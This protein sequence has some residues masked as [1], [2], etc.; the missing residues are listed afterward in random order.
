MMMDTV[1]VTFENG[2]KREYVKGI[3]FRDIIEDIDEQ[4]NFDV[5]AGMYNNQMISYDDA[6][7]KS[8]NLVLYDINTKQGNKIYE[9][10]LLFL[11]KVCVNE[12]L[13]SKVYVKVKYSIDHGIFC[14]ISKNINQEEVDKIKILMKEKVKKV[15]PFDRVETSRVE[16]INYFKKIKREDKV[17]TLFYNTSNFVTLYRFDGIYDYV[18]GDLPNDSSVFKYFD[19]T[20]IEGKGIVLR[21]PSIYDN[22]K[23]VKY[24]HHE[25]YFNSLEEYNEWGDLLNISNL[26][27]LNEAIINNNAGEIVQLS[28]IIQNYKLLS[29]A[30]SIAL[31]K[32]KI[33]IVLISGPSSSGKTTTSKKLYLYLKTLGVNPY[34][35]SLDDYFLERDETPLGEDGKPDFESLKALDIKLFNSQIQKLLKGVK[36]VTP[37][38]DFIT[39]RKMFNRPIEMK[40]NDVLIIEGLHALNTDLLKNISDENKFK[41]YIS[42]LAFLNVDDD[43]RISMTDIRLI[44]RMVRDNRT[45]G[46]SPSK[47]LASWASVRLGEEKYVFPFQDQADVVFNSSLAYELGVMKPYAEPLLYSI[48]DDDPEYLTAFRLLELFKYVLPIPSEDVPNLSIIREFIGDSYFEK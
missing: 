44:R 38:F 6:I 10:G 39:G 42:P 23:I 36:V 19:L 17:K 3:K 2:K 34:H 45:R 37:T 43:N 35:L 30:E 11:F 48:K 16:A 15:L 40:E 9:K 13:G 8:G 21:F 33:K 5:I 28:E 20:L 25:K 27:E 24:T 14:A 41:I 7:I 31:N 12:I 26:G 1:I 29:I 4:L 22:G 46:Y 18:I 47:T 32:D